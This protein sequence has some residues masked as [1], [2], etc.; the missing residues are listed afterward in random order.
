MKPT[1]RSVSE[2]L[3]GLKPHVQSA[4]FSFEM[5]SVL[6]VAALPLPLLPGLE[7]EL[8]PAVQPAASI[9]AATMTPYLVRRLMPFVLT[10]VWTLK[11]LTGRGA[12]GCARSRRLPCAYGRRMAGACA[13]AASALV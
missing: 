1:D 6:L 4:P 7:L 13:R 12:V 8:A 10:A 2:V 9:P 11:F 3:S 5:V